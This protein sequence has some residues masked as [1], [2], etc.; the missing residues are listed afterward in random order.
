MSQ[1]N[2]TDKG[3]KKAIERQPAFRLP[4]NFT[5]RTL[6]R[7]EEEAR[8]RERRAERRV[9]ILWIITLSAMLGSSLAYIVHT[10]GADMLRSFVAS[11]TRPLVLSV[12]VA[13]PLLMLFNA[14]LRQKFS[15]K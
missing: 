8:A 1:T 9:S 13:L 2:Q 15:K 14:W 12:T 3:L 11:G 5:Y 7:I 10:C 6:Q 4:T